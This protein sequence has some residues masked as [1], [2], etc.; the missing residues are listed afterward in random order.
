MSLRKP[1]VRFDNKDHAKIVAE[2]MPG[3]KRKNKQ[4][5]K[6]KKNS[7]VRKPK[8]INGRVNLK[9]AGYSGVQKVPPSQLIP[10]LPVNKVRQAAKRALTAAG[11]R[12]KVKRRRVKKATQK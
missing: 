4:T 9:V 5:K 3:V 6:A 7:S 2:L 1:L 8:V 11:H 10:Y 12:V